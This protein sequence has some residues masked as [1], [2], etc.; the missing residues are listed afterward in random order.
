MALV[1]ALVGSRLLNDLDVL[2]IRM[3]WMMLGLLP[4]LPSLH[5]HIESRWI[6]M[7]IARNGLFQSRLS[8]LSL[9]RL[10]VIV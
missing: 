10:R 9:L 7:R 1:S 5:I 2:S 4:S 8:W 6:C 3:G